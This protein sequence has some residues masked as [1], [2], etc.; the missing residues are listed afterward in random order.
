MKTPSKTERFMRRSAAV[1]TF[2]LIYVLAAAVI[3][4]QPP[5][6]ATSENILAGA[7]IIPMDNVNQGN[8]AGT[9]FNLRAYGLAN[10]FLQREIPVK[11]AIRTGKAKDGT[12][13]SADVTRIAGS[14][15][16]AGPATVAFSG[17]PFVIPREY[18]TASLRAVIATFNGQGTP[19][20]VYKTNADVTMDVR[21]T[22]EHK[23][24]IAIGPD[25]GGFGGDV[26]Q[27]TFLA[28]GITEFTS[29][30]ND[31]LTPGACYTLATQAHQDNDQFVGT[32]RTFVQSGGNLL[33]QCRSIITYEN[34]ANGHFQTNPAGYS[35]F[36]SN[37]PF[38]EINSNAFDFPGQA[39]SMPFNQF[40]GL[41]ADQDGAVTEYSYAPGGGPVNNNTV[42]VVNTGIHS[43]KMVATASKLGTGAGGVVFALG[44]HNYGRADESGE[45]D[46]ALA[47]LNGQR[48]L[49]NTVFVPA[50]NVC[51]GN[52]AVIGYKSVKAVSP[53]PVGPPILAGDTVEWTID[54]FNRSQAHQFNFQIRDI[55]GQIGGFLIWV[56]GQNSIQLYNSP[57]PGAPLTQGTLN[58]GYDGIGNDASSDLLGPNAVLPVGGRIRVRVR[59]RID[60][61]ASPLP[62]SF[63]NQS[64]ASSST[65]D[66]SDFTKTDAVDATNTALFDQDPPAPDSV[67]Q[68]QNGQVI[69]PTQVAAPTA[70]NV[71]VEGRV[72]TADGG[73]ILGALVTVTKAVTGEA[74]S[75]RTNA[76]GYFRVEDL[77]V[78]E[79]YLV[80]VSHKRY[81]FPPEPFVM[82]LDENV[83]GL[84]FIGRVGG[85]KI[86][87][88]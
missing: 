40:I 75:I 57:D 78:G 55:I 60:P 37:D 29:N 35:I 45:T 7:L 14:L 48:M 41:L 20:T 77:E 69:D 18:D 38:N 59:T 50:A 65:L 16:P 83:T 67:G 74:R 66:A 52:Q 5:G 85:T 3:P 19:V 72:T 8:A 61:N 33:L 49:L 2:F 6:P 87:P 63:F 68:I 13:F 46:S 12:D 47:F 32:Y 76:M 10:A 21:Y 43:D 81:R 51:V 9:T 26:H 44:G 53:R 79:I 27:A 82:T 42:A 70:A 28:A 25:G 34:N 15:G 30:V 62:R 54:Y 39:P 64:I 24:K 17:G 4:A 31:I 22:I 86:G 80:T 11:W 36:T 58:P 1:L 84:T 73:G 88:Q 56:P 23:P 71:F